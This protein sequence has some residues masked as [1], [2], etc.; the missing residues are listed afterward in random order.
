MLVF[1]LLDWGFLNVIFG[2]RTF[3]VMFITICI[4]L[5]LCTSKALTR[6]GIVVF[7]I[8]IS[9]VTDIIY[10]TVGWPILLFPSSIILYYVIFGLYEYIIPFLIDNFS[11]QISGLI[12]AIFKGILLPFRLFFI[13]VL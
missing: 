6:Y 8:L 9:I 10:F 2:L 4:F 1:G 7:S 13:F 3:E 12:I 5:C 11:D